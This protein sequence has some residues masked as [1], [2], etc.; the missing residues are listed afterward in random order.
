MQQERARRGSSWL[1]YHCEKRGSKFIHVGDAALLR[2]R[3]P[4]H[5]TC[6]PA[7]IGR[8]V[9]QAAARSGGWL[10]EV[11]VRGVLRRRSVDVGVLA[12]GSGLASSQR[13]A[14]VGH[15]ATSSAGAF[16]NVTVRPPVGRPPGAARPTRR[17]EP[18]PRTEQQLVDGARRLIMDGYR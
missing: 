1:R 2:A 9:A 3:F 16:A 13:R 15:A 14:R 7:H 12:G 8:E 5:Q 18:Y 4:M 11:E 6:F 17:R 10:L